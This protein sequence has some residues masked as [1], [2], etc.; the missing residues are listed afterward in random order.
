MTQDRI[1]T[2]CFISLRYV[3]HDQFL[4]GMGAVSS[5]SVAERLVLSEVE[6]S[7]SAA[8]DCPH[9]QSVGVTCAAQSASIPN[10]YK[11]SFQTTGNDK[12]SIRFIKQI[13]PYGRND[14]V[15]MVRGIDVRAAS[16]PAHLS[17]FLENARHSDRRE[18]SQ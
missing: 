18:E 4:T 14:Y 10:A 1:I 11:N 7:R 8:A 17:F 12:W 15:T 2:G 6:I 16:P 9:L 13:S 5:G 3:Q